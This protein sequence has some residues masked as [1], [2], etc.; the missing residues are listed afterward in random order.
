MV[1]KLTYHENYTT[2]IQQIRC[3]CCQVFWPIQ[4]FTLSQVRHETPQYLYTAEALHKWIKAS[5]CMESYMNSWYFM[6]PVTCALNQ[7]QPLL[8]SHNTWS[9]FWYLSDTNS[10]PDMWQLDCVLGGC[11]R[12]IWSRFRKCQSARNVCGFALIYWFLNHLP[13]SPRIEQ[14]GGGGPTLAVTHT[15]MQANE[16]RLEVMNVGSAG[17]VSRGAR[18]HTW[19]KCTPRK[20]KIQIF[21]NMGCERFVW[22]RP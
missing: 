6:Y 11:R 18:P 19:L 22:S 15:Q 2:F 17:C 20:D 14:L 8:S 16:N 10:Y 7:N 21:F 5:L 1:I 4:M 9:Y 13:P 12:A 3:S